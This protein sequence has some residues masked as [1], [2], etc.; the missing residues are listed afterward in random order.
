MDTIAASSMLMTYRMT[1]VFMRPVV[2]ALASAE[3][4]MKNTRIGAHEASAVLNSVPRS[5]MAAMLGHA[6][7][8]RDADGQA[9]DDALDEADR[10]PNLNGF[11]E[12]AHGAPFLSDPHRSRRESVRE[13]TMLQERAQTMEVDLG[14]A[15]FPGQ[16]ERRLADREKPREAVVCIGS[17]EIGSD[18]RAL[19]FAPFGRRASEFASERSSN[20]D[21]RA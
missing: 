4:T 21:E 16:K 3:I 10:A 7:A 8:R 11:L 17:S 13:A 19:C 12:D 20:E 18:Y 2:L 15:L 14:M 6:S 9:D 1:T 5:S